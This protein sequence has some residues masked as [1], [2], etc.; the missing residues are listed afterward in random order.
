MGVACKCGQ[1]R[2]CLG[3][4][5]AMCAHTLLV[6]WTRLLQVHPTPDPTQFTTAPTP[7]PT[8]HIPQEVSL[9][10]AATALQRQPHLGT[11][12]LDLEELD[13]GQ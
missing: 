2:G 5:A 1:V 10:E 13:P 11:R 3:A 7:F 12:L 9:A 6:A 8:P 4:C